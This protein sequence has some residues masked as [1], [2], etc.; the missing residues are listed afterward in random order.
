VVAF[1]KQK[2]LKADGRAFFRHYSAL[3]WEAGGKPIS[4]WQA[5]LL[6]WA[7]YH[8]GKDA[9]QSFDAGDFFDAAVRKSFKETGDV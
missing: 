3:G 1:C 9:P 2:G 4:N 5:L 8:K 7:E 6:K